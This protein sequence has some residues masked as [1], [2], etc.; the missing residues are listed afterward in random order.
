MFKTISTFVIILLAIFI[1]SCSSSNIEPT[2]M[3]P[4]NIGEPIATKS[5]PTRRAT[6]PPAKSNQASTLSPCE[7]AIVEAAEI[8]ESSDSFNDLDK[9]IRICS[10]WEEFEVGVRRHPKA[11]T[12]MLGSPGSFTT[13]T[14]ARMSCTDE[15]LHNTPV[16][17]KALEGVIFD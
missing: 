5:I 9:A 2:E 3:A 16:C 8:P 4:E 7:R 15:S 10:S 14:G 6:R 1:A 13:I 12:A 17:K 11:W